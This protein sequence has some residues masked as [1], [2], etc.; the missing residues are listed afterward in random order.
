LH[1]QDL[2]RSRAK[3]RFGRM[4]APE[5]IGHPSHASENPRRSR[6]LW[7]H[8][9]K[10]RS[11]RMNRFFCRSCRS[12]RCV[13]RSHCVGLGLHQRH[14]FALAPLSGG[15]SAV[16]GIGTTLNQRFLLEQELGRGGMGAVYSATDQVLQRSVAIKLLKE[17]SGE[18]VGKHLRLEAQIAARLLHDNVVRIYDF[19][20]AEGTWYL[21]MEQVDGTSY[22]KRW[23]VLTLAERLRILGQ[24]AE[25]L[26]YAHH[27]GVIHRDI[28]PGNVLLTAT[29][30]P[31]LSDFGLSLLAEQADEAGTI[32][33]TPHYMSPEQTKGKRLDFRTDLYSLGVMLYESAT[34]AVPFTGNAMSVMAMHAGTLPERP[35]SRNPGLSEPLEDLILALLAK[36]PEAR[37]A[38]GAAVAQALREEVDRISVQEPTEAQDA[39]AA[40]AQAEAVRTAPD[41]AAL[42]RLEQE[43][44]H[45]GAAAAELTGKTA[46]A[47]NRKR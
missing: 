11:F 44:S 16:I 28:K 40:R 17:Q 19:G 41:L 27:Q 7:S 26:D 46:P 33:G 31:K 13:D 15:G 6:L 36:K 34:G 37:P 18:E 3:V 23:R 14:G 4:S 35:R 8:L 22:V 1:S 10:V 30:V 39:A 42:A 29:D 5:T 21:V 2:R 12:C 32:R 25:A 9:E 45:G 47:R 43:D 38:S 24:V 20:Q